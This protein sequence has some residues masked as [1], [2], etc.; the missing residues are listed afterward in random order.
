[1][2]GM[3]RLLP[4]GK[5]R[6]RHVRGA[7]QAVHLEMPAKVAEE[8]RGWLKGELAKRQS[9][10]SKKAQQPPFSPGVLN[11]H[12]LERFSKL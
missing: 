11:P 5:V 6:S 3:A 12:W 2:K 4:V 9:E 7:H 8:I 10:M 1:M